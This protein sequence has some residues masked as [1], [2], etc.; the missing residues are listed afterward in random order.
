MSLPN[1]FS[2]E[3]LKSPVAR[4]LQNVIC[5]KEEGRL[6]IILLKRFVSLFTRA[7]VSSP[8][9]Y[10]KAD[11]GKWKWRKWTVRRLLSYC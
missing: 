9:T 10:N 7:S 1:S 4:R 6:L 3:R 8:W 5:G 11:A 2:K